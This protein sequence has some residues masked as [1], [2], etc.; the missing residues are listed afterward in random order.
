MS[1][2]AFCSCD[3]P[4]AKE[5]KR[6]KKLMEGTWKQEPWRNAAY[7]LSLDYA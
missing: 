7:S 4:H 5:K 1:Q 2:F 6:K 3:K